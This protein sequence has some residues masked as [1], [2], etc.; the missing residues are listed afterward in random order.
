MGVP[1]ELKIF[2]SCSDA[3]Y[4]LMDTQDIPMLI[5]S[6]VNLPVMNGLDMRKKIIL[7]D[8][9]R[10]KS[11]P[12]IFL[13]TST[14]QQ[15]IEDAYEMMVQGYFVKPNNMEELKSTIRLIY[16]YWQICLHPNV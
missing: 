8:R 1:N 15:G 3:F 6:D 13:S 9:L 4:Y 10:R 16:G 7:S 5:I 2:S 11:I 14:R 12:F